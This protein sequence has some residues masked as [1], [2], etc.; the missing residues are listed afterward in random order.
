[1]SHVYR[2]RVTSNVTSP[3][4]AETNNEEDRADVC[5]RSVRKRRLF[6]FADTTPAR[7]QP[8]PEPAPTLIPT[9]SVRSPSGGSSPV[10]LVLSRELLSIYLP[11]SPPVCAY[12]PF[13]SSFIC[14]KN[15]PLPSLSPFSLFLALPSHLFLSATDT[16]S[17]PTQLTRASLHY[18]L[19]SRQATV[20]C[21]PRRVPFNSLRSNDCPYFFGHHVDP[22]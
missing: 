13:S 2:Y 6:G 22:L 7:L 19:R 1:M 4:V 18:F 17:R 9:L 21:P 12:L 5:P 16:P 11:P 10:D 14:H 8:T 15:V 20:Y 3:V